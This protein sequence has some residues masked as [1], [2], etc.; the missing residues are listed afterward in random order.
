MNFKNGM[1]CPE[2]IDSISELELNEVQLL[3]LDKWKSF[4]L[5][6]KLERED[7]DSKYLLYAPFDEPDPDYESSHNRTFEWSKYIVGGQ[8]SRYTVQ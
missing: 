8:D 2:F 7:P 3:H 1:V 5:K 6:I 4:E